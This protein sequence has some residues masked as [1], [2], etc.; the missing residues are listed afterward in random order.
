MRDKNS[1]KE[2]ISDKEFWDNN[3]ERKLASTSYRNDFIQESGVWE[4]ILVIALACCDFMMF[5]QLFESVIYDNVIILIVGIV[6]ILVAFDGAPIYIGM[7]MK[8]KS[9]GFR[10]RKETI[11]GG[12]LAVCIGLGIYVMLRFSTKD[13]SFRDFSSVQSI[14]DS[15]VENYNASPYAFQLALSYAFLPVATSLMSFIVSFTASNP[16]K[17]RLRKLDGEIAGLNEEIERLNT[18]QVEFEEREHL[19]DRLLDMDDERLRLS[20]QSAY[21]NAYYFG[22]YVRER[23]KEHLADPTS[24]NI[25]SK[26]NKERMEM[27]LE[28]QGEG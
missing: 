24:T 10:A 15:A 21:E 18:M 9:Q 5:K 20:K 27:L 22:D 13:A 1:N 6:G 12:L 8:K 4:I 16:L 17:T 2:Q 7:E 14:F 11:I 25:L 23:L 26:D 28:K 19:Y 3:L